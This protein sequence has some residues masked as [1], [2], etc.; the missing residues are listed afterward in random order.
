M[1]QNYAFFF[2]TFS[3]QPNNT[4]ARIRNPNTHTQ[5]FSHIFQVK[6]YKLEKKANKNFN[7]K[8]RK[9]KKHASE[10]QNLNLKVYFLSLSHIF[11]WTNQ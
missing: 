4:E 5:S 10:F 3:L 8:P 9:K 2:T 1:I 7:S 6:I 11:S